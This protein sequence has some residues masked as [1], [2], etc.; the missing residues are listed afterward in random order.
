MAARDNMAPQYAILVANQELGPEITRFVRSVEYESADGIADMA[1][2]KVDNP[3]FVFTD[4]K[5]WQAGNEIQI[6]M[7]Y[8][9][10]AYI[11]RVQTVR[12][13]YDYPEGSAMPTIEVTG[14]TRDHLM[15]DNAPAEK[16]R[17][18]PWPDATIRE[19]LDDKASVY[20]FEL[21][22]D[23]FAFGRSITQKAGLSDYDLIKGLANLSGYL[24]WVDADADGRWILHFRRPDERTGLV[25]GVQ[26]KKFT[27]RYNAGDS[28]TLL[29]FRPEYAIRDV[30]TKLRVQVRNPDTGRTTEEEIEDDGTAPDLQSTGDPK[31]E[32]EDAHSTGAA[33]KLFFG[34]FSIETVANKPFKTAKEARDW[35]LQWFRRNRENFVTGSG[36][37]IGVET[38]F[39]RQ[40]H[41]FAGLGKTLDGDY[42]LSRVRHV[43]TRDKGYE[44]EIFGRKVL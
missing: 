19:I 40:S 8:G 36:K 20:G 37:T 42:Y 24:F 41:A 11:G 6:F 10:A 23:D 18:R 15:M 28:T 39:A 34:E 16:P 44:C 9:Q 29:S 7:G 25:P 5:L 21:D 13:V 1:K 38:L 22:V 17:P 4:S 35:A 2:I 3:N 26:E 33:I 30:K 31:E 43:A 27:F 14:Y 32:A 12:P